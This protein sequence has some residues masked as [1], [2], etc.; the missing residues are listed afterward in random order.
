MY[1]IKD[2]SFIKKLEHIFNFLTNINNKIKNG[3][4]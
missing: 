1:K 4:Y 3:K 2:V